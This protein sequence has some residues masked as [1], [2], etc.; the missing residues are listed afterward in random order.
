IIT[1][2]ANHGK[3]GRY[4]EIARRLALAEDVTT[5]DEAR[6]LAAEGR[7]VGWIDGGLHANEVLGAQQL[8]ELVYEL[9]S[10][11]DPETLRFLDDV[12]VLATHANPD[13]DELVANWYLRESDPL[14]RS[15]AA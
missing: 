6:A 1:S 14:R 3:L 11:D 8:I 7:A 9:T 10:G 13:G 2:P 15:T 12:I 5:E 4:R